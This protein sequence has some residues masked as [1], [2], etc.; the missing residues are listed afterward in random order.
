MAPDKKPEAKIGFSQANGAAHHNSPKKPV[1][2]NIT[3]NFTAAWY[4]VVMNTGVLG[5]LYHNQP[6]QFAGLQ[7]IASIM[8]VLAIVLFTLFSIPTIIRWTVFFQSTSKKTQ[9]NIDEISMLG[10]PVIAWTQITALTALI[11][12]NA[13]WG[14]ESFS[15][16][17]VVMWWFGTAW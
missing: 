13:S 3:E 7:T 11:A 12:S 10:A 15:I 2:R 17:A 8:Y 9:G 4:T 1:W 5:I 14:G 16:L 6:H